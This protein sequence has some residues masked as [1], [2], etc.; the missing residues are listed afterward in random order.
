MS[1]MEGVDLKA[2]GDVGAQRIAQIY[3]EAFL[4]AAQ[5]EGQA[6]QALS[7][8]RSLVVDVFSAQPQLENLFSSGA[9]GRDR[10]ATLIRNVFAN[11]ASELLT[12]FLLVL[13]HHERLNLL[14]SILAAAA[15]LADER[16]HRVKVRVRSAVP[17]PQDQRDHLRDELRKSL[18]LEPLLRVEVDPQLIGGLV[19]QVG[20]WQ[21]DG[22]VRTQLEMLRNQLIERSSYEIQSRRD[23]FCSPNGN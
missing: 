18:K 16:A 17:L 9:I 21:Y 11:R 22:S 13:N 6:E 10:K 12:N 14:R 15:D 1:E 8:L 7:E 19:V 20:D 4:N 5:K 23:R 2:T 3:A